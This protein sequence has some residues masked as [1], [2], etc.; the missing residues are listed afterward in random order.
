[1]F[2]I[3]NDVPVVVPW[4]DLWISTAVIFLPGMKFAHLFRWKEVPKG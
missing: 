2:G 3:S 4:S 1:L